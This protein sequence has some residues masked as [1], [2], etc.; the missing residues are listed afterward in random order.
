MRLCDRVLLGGSIPFVA[1]RLS[2]A[3][4]MC[5]ARKGKRA[6]QM[7]PFEVGSAFLGK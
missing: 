2:H 6:P 1:R 3:P 5:I 7:A 4:D